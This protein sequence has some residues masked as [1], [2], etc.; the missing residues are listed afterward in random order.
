MMPPVNQ[1]E[2]TPLPGGQRSQKWVI[3]N[4]RPSSKFTF[5]LV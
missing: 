1:V 3:H 4:L 5:T 2:L